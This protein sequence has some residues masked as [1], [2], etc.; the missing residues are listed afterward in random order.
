VFAVTSSTH[1]DV[2]FSGEDMLSLAASMTCAQVGLPIFLSVNG[3]NN[4]TYVTEVVLTRALTEICHNAR[5]IY[6]N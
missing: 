6:L 3:T 1:R 4:N 5:V 2:T